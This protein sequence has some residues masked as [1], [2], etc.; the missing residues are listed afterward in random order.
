MLCVAFSSRM[1]SSFRP[2][3]PFTKEHGDDA[4]GHYI[5][6]PVDLAAFQAYAL[7]YAKRQKIP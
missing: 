2:I 4:A 7:A 6:L 3:L 1:G 5:D